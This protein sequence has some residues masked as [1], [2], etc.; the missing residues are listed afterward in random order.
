[1][2][3]TERV[4]S[5]I[6]PM[7]GCTVAAPGTRT[8][9]ADPQSLPYDKPGIRYTRNLSLLRAVLPNSIS[10]TG[11]GTRTEISMFYAMA[12]LS[13]PWLLSGKKKKTPRERDRVPV[14]GAGVGLWFCLG[15]G[16]CGK[17]AGGGKPFKYHALSGKPFG[18]H[19][20]GNVPSKK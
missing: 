9:A 18:Y 11:T 17:I 6:R 19:R 15:L 4:S 13:L 10:H 5:C 1:M 12:S 16:I 20:P 2:Y 3:W 14:W 8:I 7:G